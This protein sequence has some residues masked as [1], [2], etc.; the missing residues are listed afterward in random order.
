MP[1]IDRRRP[2]FGHEKLGPEDW[3]KDYK[4][5]KGSTDPFRIR[6]EAIADVKSVLNMPALAP[7]KFPLQMGWQGLKSFIPKKKEYNTIE[8]YPPKP[9]EF[10]DEPLSEAELRERDQRRIDNETIRQQVAKERAADPWGF[11]IKQN[12]TPSE[13]K[14]FEALGKD[15]SSSLLANPNQ[16][17]ESKTNTT[18]ASTVFSMY[19]K[20]PGQKPT[21]V[22]VMSRAQRRK[23]EAENEFVFNEG[24]DTN[25]V[26]KWDMCNQ[27]KW[28][29]RKDDSAVAQNQA[30]QINVKK[31]DKK[32]PKPNDPT[33][34]KKETKKTK[35][36]K[37]LTTEDKLDLAAQSLKIMSQ[38]FDEDDKIAWRGTGHRWIS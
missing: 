8:F 35:S 11:M 32:E 34:D 9:G 7:L 14:K 18:P 10:A 23:W 33:P 31:G 36:F 26:S 21:A 15:S 20:R 28:R 13:R 25:K 3:D 22:G 1:H 6:K 17:A 2:D 19:Q 37:D 12:M 27:G 4:A 16:S 38:L 29:P 30:A 5:K 24:V